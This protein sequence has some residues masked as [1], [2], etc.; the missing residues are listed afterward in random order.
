VAKK[1]GYGNVT[2]DALINKFQAVDK[3]FIWYLKEFLLS[4]SFLLPLTH[5]VLFGMFKHLS[6]TLP[7]IPQVSDK[8]DLTD[9]IR[10]IL[11]APLQD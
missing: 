1:P 9:K 11:P 2:A 8:A 4:H 10:T 7:Q 6:V 3:H 5:N